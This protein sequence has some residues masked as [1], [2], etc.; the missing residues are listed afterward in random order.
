MDN[1]SVFDFI[2]PP[3]YLVLVLVT[4]NFIKKNNIEKSPEYEYFLKGLIIKIVGAIALG[5]IYS[6]YYN[7][8][9]TIN[10]FQTAN[11]YVSLAF[12]DFN[13][14][15]EGWLGNPIYLNSI[16]F[17]NEDTG[18]PVYFHR[19][20]HSFFIVR[21]LIPIVFLAGKTYFSAT[22]LTAFITFSGVWKLYQMFVEE[23]SVLKKELAIA[24]IFLPSCVFWGSGILKDSF[25]LS[26]VGWFSYSFYNLLIK[27]KF[28]LKFIISILISSTVLIAVKPYI[29]F[30]LLP[31]SILWLSNNQIAKIS[32]SILRVLIAPFL[33][34]LGLLGGSF[35]LSK[36]GDNLGLYKVD[37]VLER[38]TVV[39]KDM[40][41]DYYGGKS[42]DIGEFDASIEGIISK[43][44]QAIFA[45]LFRPGIWDVKNAVMLISSMENTIL[46]LL[47]IFLLIKLKFFGFFRY[48]GK[49]PMLMF[50]MLFALF[51]SFA[52]GLTVANFGSLVRLR[53]P[54]LPFYM[55]SIFII[56][57]FY[58][59]S[60]LKIN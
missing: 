4:A 34:A 16:S 28:N 48:I 5:L 22:I 53:I 21:L 58:N 20:Q 49:N 52:V 12:Y 2:F 10:Y 37:T 51:F 9:D 33:I 41:A 47:T 32:N 19:D 39:Q 14:F 46:L 43:A 1:L 25:T 60:R 13:N 42:F 23:F 44:P 29:F 56:R 35:S 59:Q 36:L 6:F 30:A 8:G 27:R 31:G 24:I 55:A 15:I 45:G 17:F 3:F 40:K 11:A 7:G 26:A 54:S 38:A 18:Y 50:A 57:H